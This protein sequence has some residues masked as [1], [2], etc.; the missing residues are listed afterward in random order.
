MRRRSEVKKQRLDDEKRNFEIGDDA[1]RLVIAC[2]LNPAIW[3]AIA[4]TGWHVEIRRRSDD[5]GDCG[6]LK[7][8]CYTA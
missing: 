7:R 2:G 6:S 1:D 3:E 5:S 4:G 8:V